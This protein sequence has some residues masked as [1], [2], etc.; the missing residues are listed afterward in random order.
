MRYFNEFKGVKR[1]LELIANISDI[2]VYDDFAHHPTAIKKTTEAL[3]N[4][5]KHQAGTVRLSRLIVVFEP[6]SNSLK[7]GYGKEQLAESFKAAD[8]VYVYDGSVDWDV[9]STLNNI[10][11]KVYVESEVQSILN[12]LSSQVR[13]GDTIVFM[14]NGDFNGIV[15]EFVKV[16][17]LKKFQ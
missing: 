6:R 15:K 8:I 5:S 10:G 17:D 1:R 13:I 4:T 3:R 2:K 9:R 12:R 14:S 7:L 11:Q 16:L